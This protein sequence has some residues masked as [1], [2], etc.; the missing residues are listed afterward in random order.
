M[1]NFFQGVSFLIWGCLLGAAAINVVG[2]IMGAIIFGYG[3]YIITKSKKPK[4]TLTQLH[5]MCK[6]P[7]AHTS[8]YWEDSASRNKK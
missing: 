1:K 6:S 4:P 3:V 7:D 8:D 5:K 2:N